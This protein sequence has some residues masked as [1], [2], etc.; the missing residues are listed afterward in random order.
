MPNVANRRPLVSEDVVGR[1]K[2]C[3]ELVP[4]PL[5]VSREPIELLLVADE[6]ARLQLRSPQRETRS[7]PAFAQSSRAF[8]KASQR[9]QVPA[10]RI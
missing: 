6:D 4:E 2:T 8:A 1:R 3:V 9:A 7:L 5:G 10:I